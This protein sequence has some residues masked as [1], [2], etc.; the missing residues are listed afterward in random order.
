MQQPPGIPK[1]SYAPSAAGARKRPDG[2]EVKWEVT[3]P[4]V[5]TGYQRGELPFFCHDVTPRIL[6]VPSAKENLTHPKGA[7]G[8]K[9]LHIYVPEEKVKALAKAYEAILGTENLGE[10]SGQGHFH[11]DALH[12][13]NRGEE[14]PFYALFHVEKP[15]KSE[16]YKAMEENGGLL[17]D[18]LKIFGKG[19]AIRW[20]Y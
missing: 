20:G 9:E 7:L 3:F 5:N 12:Q 6:R 18:D 8:I 4:I 19:T 1:A 11:L 10:R 15:T 2:Q 14:E 13:V 16:Q 17:I